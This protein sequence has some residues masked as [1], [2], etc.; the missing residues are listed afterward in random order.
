MSLEEQK[1]T[2]EGVAAHFVF[3]LSNELD[4]T[5]RAIVDEHLAKCPHCRAQFQEE[6]SFSDAIESIPQAAD[7]LDYSGIVLSQCRSELA[8]KLDDLARPAVNDDALRFGWFRRWMILHPAWSGGA[9]VLDELRARPA[10]RHV[11]ERALP[12]A[13]IDKTQARHPA[14]R[15]DDDRLAERRGMVAI[16]K[17]EIVA[18][19]VARGQRLMGDEE[20]MQPA[21][22]GEADVISRVEHA[23][24]IAQKRTRPLDGD[25]L[26]KRLR[27]E[28]GPAFEDMLEVGGRE[29]DMAGDR[30]D[31]R[32]VA[33]AGGDEFER[34]L[35][36][37]VIAARGRGGWH[38]EHGLIRISSC[39]RPRLTARR[40]P[41]LTRADGGRPPENDDPTRIL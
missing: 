32:L 3:Y 26:Q 12:V 35:D 8:E 9:L 14:R 7:Q 19:V 30:L 21:R 38:I 6:Q 17:N 39:R 40:R 16:A 41:T 28:P 1:F 5:E 4:E 15:R 25:R 13:V 29:A 22:A 20:V 23:R 33:I 2:C 11:G 10:P 24:R 27:R 34:V 31:R 36:G 37:G 18:S